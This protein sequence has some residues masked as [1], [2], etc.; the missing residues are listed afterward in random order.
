[1]IPKVT[2]TKVE[3]EKSRYNSSRAKK[4]SMVWLSKSG[5]KD[6]LYRIV[7]IA[8]DLVAE[9]GWQNGDRVTLYKAGAALFMLKREK[10]GLETVRNVSKKQ[11]SMRIN[12]ISLVGA[13][14]PSVNGTEFD[15]WTDGDAIIFKPKRKEIA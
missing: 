10:V 2:W 6:K 15:A 5:S 1:M 7:N 9:A 8:S 14:G 12:S 13:I 3:Y 11:G 4:P